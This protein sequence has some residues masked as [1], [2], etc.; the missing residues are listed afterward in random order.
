MNNL[1]LIR[2]L[3]IFLISFLAIGCGNNSDTLESSVVQEPI[4]SRTVSASLCKVNMSI[5]T[6]PYFNYR[7]NGEDN[8]D[9]C[10]I[11]IDDQDFPENGPLLQA[12]D[13][14][15]TYV[16]MSPG[17]HKIK[18]MI[19]I[20]DG[21]AYDY[22]CRMCGFDV[23]LRNGNSSDRIFFKKAGLEENP[24]SVTNAI[25]LAD[26]Y[27]SVSSKVEYNL[28]VNLTLY[29]ETDDDG[30]TAPPY[31]YGYV[32]VYSYHQWDNESEIIQ[33][34]TCRF[35]IGTIYD[36]PDETEF[37]YTPLVDNEN[38]SVGS[39][40]MIMSKFN[41]YMS[42]LKVPDSGDFGYR[43]YVIAQTSI[44]YESGQSAEEYVSW[45][46]AF[47]RE[48]YR[49]GGYSEWYP[50]DELNASSIP[51]IWIDATIDIY[52]N[53]EIVCFNTKE[54]QDAYA[55]SWGIEPNEY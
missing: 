4:R 3:C 18:L 7:F 51:T 40:L 37:I 1:R 6:K 13:S 20:D 44:E 23:F 25:F 48:K 5:F 30:S 15:R 36:N 42:G 33:P 29:D 50:V 19:K 32:R 28:D 34:T 55:P 10:Y 8:I 12:N 14:V 24:G 17:L 53:F 47:Y 54:I 16:Y 46:S 41:A 49:G 35:F 39:N 2:L 22:P 9:V 45:Y 26:F 31:K 21:C 43:M 52:S 27:I 38:I 11:A